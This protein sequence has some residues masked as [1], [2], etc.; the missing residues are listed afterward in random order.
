MRYQRGCEDRAYAFLF[1]RPRGHGRRSMAYYR[2][3]GNELA[4]IENAVIGQIHRLHIPWRRSVSTSEIM[5]IGIS[6]GMTKPGAVAMAARN[7]IVRHHIFGVIGW[8]VGSL[9]VERADDRRRH[10][11]DRIGMSMARAIINAGPSLPTE[12]KRAVAQVLARS[13]MIWQHGSRLTGVLITANERCAAF[14]V[15]SGNR[16]A[17]SGICMLFLDGSLRA[18]R[19]SDVVSGC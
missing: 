13:Q 6:M 16:P 2:R 19:T 9:R 11:G 18:G 8:H 12:L 14:T 3:A 5:S 4:L 15:S 17:T 1:H 7:R 10:S